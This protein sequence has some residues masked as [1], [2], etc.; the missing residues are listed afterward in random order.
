MGV[1]SHI[2]VDSGIIILKYILFK[3]PLA[4]IFDF[5]RFP[6]KISI[7]LERHASLFCFYKYL[8][9]PKTIVKPYLPKVGHGIMVLDPTISGYYVDRPISFNPF[10]AK[11]NHC[12][13]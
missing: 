10:V 8:K 13:F 9:L 3:R 7:F 5:C 2:T 11:H 6:F 1:V 12:S 4:I